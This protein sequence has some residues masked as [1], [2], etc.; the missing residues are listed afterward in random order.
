MRRDS[1]PIG[2]P[3]NRQRGGT[4][5]TLRT[6]SEGA[7]GEATGGTEGARQKGREAEK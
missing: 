7:C 6:G 2:A 4:S 1:A 3:Q 5:G